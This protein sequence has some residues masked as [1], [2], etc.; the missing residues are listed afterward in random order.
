MIFDI[1]FD[2][3]QKTH[4]ILNGDFKAGFVSSLLLQWTTQNVLLKK[5]T[6]RLARAF[7]V[8]DRHEWVNLSGMP[9]M[10]YLLP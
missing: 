10:I 8:L 5:D 1:I 6:T 2:I 7:F 9:H 3:E 4:K